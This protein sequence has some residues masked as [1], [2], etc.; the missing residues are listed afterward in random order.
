MLLYSTVL[1][2]NTSMWMH[3]KPNMARHVSIKI[4][5]RDKVP[6][7]RHARERHKSEW[8][9]GGRDTA[10]TLEAYVERLSGEERLRGAGW[11]TSANKHRPI[12]YLFFRS[13]CTVLTVLSSG[14]SWWH[15]LGTTHA[16]EIMLS[17]KGESSWDDKSLA[18]FPIVMWTPIVRRRRRASS[19][20]STNLIIIMKSQSP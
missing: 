6:Q 20:T 19:T 12:N 8:R 1:P 16:R 11:G 18:I 14:Y 4:L 15:R 17:S 9:A 7:R 5:A 3:L 13:S 10:Q 2:R